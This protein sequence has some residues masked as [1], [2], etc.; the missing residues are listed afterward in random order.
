MCFQSSLSIIKSFQLFLFFD[1][2]F[3]HIFYLVILSWVLAILYL[4]SLSLNFS[5]LIFISLSFPLESWMTFLRLFLTW[6][7]WF[8]PFNPDCCLMPFLWSLNYVGWAFYFSSFLT[9]SFHDPP[10]SHFKD[11]VCFWVLLK[12]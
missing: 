9:A 1:D 4:T 10:L 2:F 12:E 11:S 6:M 8:F 3:C 7:I 5:F